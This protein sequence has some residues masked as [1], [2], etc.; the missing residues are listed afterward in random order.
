MEPRLAARPV[1]SHQRL[2]HGSRTVRARDDLIDVGPAGRAQDGAE[3][4]VAKARIT[5]EEV[6]VGA[7][8]SAVTVERFIGNSCAN[9][10]LNEVDRVMRYL[11]LDSIAELVEYER[12][13]IP[14]KPEK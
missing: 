6:A 10:T 5:V 8:I 1:P 9:L 3:I 12:N 11:E 2:D 13:V 4:V 14:I 7:N